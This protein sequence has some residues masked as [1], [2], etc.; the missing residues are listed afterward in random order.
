MS[1]LALSYDPDESQM[2]PHVLLAHKSYTTTSSTQS[3]LTSIQKPK[4]G[5]RVLLHSCCAPC[6][7]AMIYEMSRL[8][9]DITV[10]FYNPNIH[11]RRE[12][13]IRKSENKN[14]CSSLS[15]PFVDAEYDPEVW[16]DKA[17][18]MEGDAERGNRCTM[19]FDMRMEK[20][21]EYAK[22]NG[23]HVIATTNATSRWKDA[24]Q[25]DG[26]GIRAAG[27][28]GLEYFAANWQTDR[29]TLLKYQISAGEKFYKQEYCGC[30]YSL[31]D[32][33][34]W[35]AANGIGKIRIGGDKAGLGER[36]FTDPE[37]DAE[38]ESVEV[39]REFF[40]SANMIA[41]CVDEVSCKGDGKSGGKDA[42]GIDKKKLEEERKRLWEI[43]KERKK[44]TEE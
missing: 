28:Y 18:G 37:K 40:E 35:R 23:F 39:V 25:V 7:G 34:L 31:R 44:K 27:K 43:Y 5:N 21:A 10:F 17:K 16:Y 20:T 11:P 42:G 6:S 30:S 26:S 9:L 24:A 15:I 1:S 32:S 4:S 29:M 2:P 3:E 41:S 33:N 19:C 12:Y 38:E 14:F 36:Y 13:L 8:D 22:E